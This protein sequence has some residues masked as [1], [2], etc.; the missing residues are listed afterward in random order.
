MTRYYAIYRARIDDP[1]LCPAKY[2]DRDYDREGASDSEAHYATFARRLGS[3]TKAQIKELIIQAA[4]KEIEIQMSNKEDWRVKQEAYGIVFLMCDDDYHTLGV[5][6]DDGIK[7][8]LKRARR[9]YRK[10]V[11]D[12]KVHPRVIKPLLVCFNRAEIIGNSSPTRTEAT[13]IP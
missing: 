13:S 4:E 5:S 11:Y 6:V 8:D 2:Y 12:K 1:R 9:Y 7:A 3:L 10:A